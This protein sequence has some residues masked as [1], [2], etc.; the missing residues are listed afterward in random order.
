MSA[1]PLAVTGA[2]G[3]VGQRLLERAATRGLELVC[4]TRRLQPEREGVSWVQGD[5]HDEGALARLCERADSVVHIAGVISAPDAAGFE[6]GNVAGTKNLIA[7]AEGAGVG[8]FVHVSSLAAREPSLSLY[9]ASKARSESAVRT[10][11]LDQ[12]IVR[13]PAVYGPGD[14]ETLELF[15]FAQRGFVPLPPKGRLSLIHADDLADLLLDLAA[16]KG[17]AGLTLEPDDN[18]PG[19]W[20]HEEFAQAIGKALGREHVTT[21]SMPRTMV[22]LGAQLD[23]LVRGDGAKLTPDRAAYFCHPDWTV[24]EG[25]RPE[26]S[27]WQPA[28][29]TE[30]GLA[31]TARWYREQGWLAGDKALEK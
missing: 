31:D 12:Q 4:L 27:L 22:R 10:S 23:K 14:R 16:G 30:R 9:G 29:P 19:G 13:P 17:R 11:R 5:L 3:F 2:T 18:R 20:S 25:H 8:R 26:P 28:I 21:L 24:A 6:H 15:Q 1:R 7:A